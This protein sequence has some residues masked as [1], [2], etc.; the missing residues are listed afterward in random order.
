MINVGTVRYLKIPEGNVK[1]IT[2][3]A[4]GIMLWKARYQNLVPTSIDSDGSIFNGCGYINGCRVRSSG[5]TVEFPNAA[6]TGYIPVMAGDTVR[7][8]GGNWSV[9]DSHNCLHYSDENFVAL[10][11][12]TPQP[13]YYGICHSKNS[14]IAESNGVYI[15]IV[16]DNANIRYLRMSLYGS[17]THGA[18][19]VV[20][21]N[22]EID[23]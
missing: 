13:A 12:F 20:T 18:D 17:G 16:P 4:D 14:D 15:H 6:A 10:G 2:R 3:K 19:M 8:K 21:V 5:A 22:E 7:F 11:S 23:E 9:S 1:T